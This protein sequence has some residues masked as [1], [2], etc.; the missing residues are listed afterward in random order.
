MQAQLAKRLLGMLAAAALLAAP[1]RA[2]PND[3]VYTVGNYPVDAQAKNAV[4]AKDKALAD[5]QEAAFHSLLKRIVPVTAYDRL[6][7]LSTL[8]SADFFEG[9]GVRSERNSRTR[10]IASLDFSFRAESVRAVLR[11]AGIP[12]VEEQ[13]KQVIVVP[14]VRRADGTI[15]K[16]NAARTWADIWKTLDL[17]HSLTPID[18]QVLKPEI[19]PDTVT[20]LAERRGG[21]EHILAGQ[22]GTPLVVLAIAEPDAAAK[23]LNVTL[24]GVDAA[25]PLN[26]RRSYRVYDGDTGYAMELAAVVGQGVLD[27]RWKAHKVGADLVAQG[28]PVAM[29]AHYAS[30]A[31]WRQ[32]REKLLAMVGVQDMRIESESARSASLSLRYP[33]GTQ[34]FA[35]AL[36]GQGL[37]L[38]RGA[39]GLILRAGGP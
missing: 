25:G 35:A 3:E 37:A 11:Q 34:P 38:Y 33:G 36:N 24:A 16:G 32:M 2:A 14:I 18:L 21:A 26:L 30:L 9:V 1:A 6:K 23:R 12:F 8:N 28:P 5:G 27:G 39:D 15:D 10:Y 20:Q 19:Q 31:E 13:A 7:Q 29:Q 17:E 4:A 22:Y